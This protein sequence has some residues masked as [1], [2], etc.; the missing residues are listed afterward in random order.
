MSIPTLTARKPPALV[1]ALA[2]TLAA[3]TGPLA[4]SVG[5]AA[6]APTPAAQ[7]LVTSAVHLGTLGG[8]ATEARDIDG[9]LIVGDSQTSSGATHAYAFD[10]SDSTMRD[11]GTLGGTYSSATAVDGTVVAGESKTASGATHAFAVDLADATPTMRDLGALGGTYSSATA[12]SGHVVVGEY[13]QP[14]TGVQRAFFYDLDAATPTMRSLGTL[15]GNGP[16]YVYDIDGPVIVGDASRLGDHS[17]AFAYD[18]SATTPTMRDLGT[19][20]GGSDSS[21]AA[22]DG[23]LVV[24]SSYAGFSP[25]ADRAFYYDLSAASPAMHPLAGEF[26]AGTSDALDVSGT[27]VVGSLW[28]FAAEYPFVAD[29]AAANPAMRRLGTLMPG[30]YAEGETTGID[31]NVVVGWMRAPNGDFRMF[32]EDLALPHPQ[33]E[34]FGSLGSDP[35]P[36]VSGHTVVGENDNTGNERVTAYR[37]STTTAPSVRFAQLTTPV[38]ENAGRAQLTV[39][40]DGDNSSPVSVGYTTSNF[41]GATGAGSPGSDFPVTSGTVTLAAGQQTA[42]IPIPIRN[43]TRRELS[44]LVLVSLRTPSAGSRVHTLAQAFVSIAASDQRPDASVAARKKGHYEG[45]RRYNVNGR[46]Q[47]ASSHVR[48][49]HAHTFFVRVTNHGRGPVTYV[50]HGSAPAAGASVRYF[51]GARDVTAAMSSAAGLSLRVLARHPTPLRA[52]VST[53]AHA[54]GR[55]V[56]VVRAAW[57]GDGT[58]V[59]VVRAALRVSR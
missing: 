11:L 22:I 42:T 28:P 57:H 54:Q 2:C 19:L 43:D 31:G 49:G 8:A 41:D 36:M 29:L 23:N 32:V 12:V 45:Q 21:A 40:R 24:G 15:G 58:Q 50:V 14:P 3:A 16:S 7:T 5:P 51:M 4:A 18:L 38:Q 47:V 35:A 55:K 13:S 48:A 44:E 9:D 56:V 53:A 26:A 27:R 25:G 20:G 39:V 33:L 52:V 10:L 37:L 17:H 6:A 46:Q 34:A 30:F 1:A 59:D